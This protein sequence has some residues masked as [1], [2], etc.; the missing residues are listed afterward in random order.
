MVLSISAALGP[1]FSVGHI[2]PDATDP[3]IEIARTGGVQRPG[4]TKLEIRETEELLGREVV[5]EKRPFGVWWSD[6]AKARAHAG[7]A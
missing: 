3:A 2:I 1:G 7:E 6:W 4:N 5:R